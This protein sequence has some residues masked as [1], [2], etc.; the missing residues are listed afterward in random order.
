M[1][2]MMSI[3]SGLGV[4]ALLLAANSERMR[5]AVCSQRDHHRIA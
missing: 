2:M 4:E 5:V 3:R 1:R